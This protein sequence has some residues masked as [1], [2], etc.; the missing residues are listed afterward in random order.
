MTPDSPIPAG[1]PRAKKPRDMDTLMLFG[2]TGFVAT[3][4]GTYLLTIWPYM[5]FLN[6]SEMRMLMLGA[7]LGMA[8]ALIAG[9]IV[10]RKF[11]LPGAAGLLGGAMASGVFLYLRLRQALMFRGVPEAPQPEY[12]DAFAWMVPVGWVVA[13]LIVILLFIPRDEVTVDGNSRP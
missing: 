6:I 5:V 9:A 10:C 4:V 3:S 8:P 12:P 7:G 2:C 11:G 13:T 1:S